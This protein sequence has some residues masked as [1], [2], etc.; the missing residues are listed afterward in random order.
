MV[1]LTEL[2]LI[3]LG[4]TIRLSRRANWTRCILVKTSWPD[5]YDWITGLMCCIFRCRSISIPKL[6]PLSRATCSCSRSHIYWY[7]WSV[8]SRQSYFKQASPLNL[9][10]NFKLNGRLI[11]CWKSLLPTSFLT[12]VILQ[13]RKFSRGA[14]KDYLTFFLY[15]STNPNRLY[16]LELKILHSAFFYPFIIRFLLRSHNFPNLSRFSA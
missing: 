7:R 16:R 1:C 11:R 12:P 8:T 6:F 5:K 9:T 4:Q 2:N 14:F 3:C 10:G 15:D 13:V